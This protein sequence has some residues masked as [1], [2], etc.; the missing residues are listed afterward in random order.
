ML[1]ASH[2]PLSLSPSEGDPRDYDRE[3]ETVTLDVSVAPA[4]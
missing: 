4:A 3:A 2:W 1:S